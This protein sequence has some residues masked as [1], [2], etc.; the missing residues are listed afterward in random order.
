MKDDLQKYLETVCV[1][2]FWVKKQIAKEKKVVAVINPNSIQSAKQKFNFK[3]L[4]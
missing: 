2:Q 3:L 4:T 1:Y